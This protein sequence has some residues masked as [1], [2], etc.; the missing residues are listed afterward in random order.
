MK[1]WLPGDRIDW[2]ALGFLAFVVGLFL[3]GL[4]LYL[5]TAYKLGGRRRVV[6]D[7]F[8][9]VGALVLLAVEQLTRKSLIPFLEGIVGRVTK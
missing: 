4:F 2:I 8:V 7:L 5:R 9:A 6:R 1:D 3:I